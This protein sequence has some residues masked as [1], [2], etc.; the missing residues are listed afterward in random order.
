MLDGYWLDQFKTL[1]LP[2]RY[3]DEMV[4]EAQK[5]LDR[6][7]D[8][9]PIE[10]NELL[11][12][13]S[14]YPQLDFSTEGKAL[15]LSG[16]VRHQTYAMLDSYWIEQAKFLPFDTAQRLMNFLFQLPADV[17]K[18]SDTESLPLLQEA[19]VLSKAH[20]FLERE[21][22]NWRSSPDIVIEPTLLKFIHQWSRKLTLRDDARLLILLSILHHHAYDMLD[23]FWQEQ[24]GS[25]H[26]ELPPQLSTT[27][28]KILE[29]KRKV[30]RSQSTKGSSK[31]VEMRSRE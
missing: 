6:K 2:G 11:L 16:I 30:K 7:T 14:C 19:L 8:D 18:Q 20:S 23:D 5:L 26:S 12:I 31:E 21:L 29:Q 27:L 3:I 4:K 22:V 24:A 9:S 25:L 15:V 28:S 10:M 1:T 13:H 17:T